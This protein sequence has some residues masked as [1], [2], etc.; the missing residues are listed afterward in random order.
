MPSVR[1]GGSQLTCFSA[2]WLESSYA[3]PDLG[4]PQVMVTTLLGLP[5]R[6]CPGTMQADLRER[7]V[8]IHGSWPGVCV[9]QLH[10]CSPS[11][12]VQSQKGRG[13][14]LVGFRKPPAAGSEHR[15]GPPL[16]PAAC[17]RGSWAPSRGWFLRLFRLPASLSPPA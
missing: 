14:L 1:L 3:L 5:T 2:S 7:G 17:G 15:V 10:Q 9:C 6:W 12:A 13:L 16:H 8:Y 4:R 11:H